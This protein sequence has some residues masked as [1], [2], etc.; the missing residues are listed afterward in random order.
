M[1]YPRRHS[2]TAQNS[3][4]RLSAPLLN[5]MT[6]LRAESKVT[7]QRRKMRC[8]RHPVDAPVP[9]PDIASAG[10]KTCAFCSYANKDP[11]L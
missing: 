7:A 5:N 4:D 8:A 11:A 6:K 2:V 3:G 9:L 1:A 10:G